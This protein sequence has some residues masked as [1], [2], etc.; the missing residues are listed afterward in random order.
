LA[1]R[2]AQFLGEDAASKPIYERMRLAYE[3]RSVLVHGGKPSSDRKLKKLD[4]MKFAGEIGDD[5]QA[6]IFKALNLLGT[7]EIGES[8]GD[9]FWNNYLFGST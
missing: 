1:L 8:L 7:A 9:E 6:A 4:L 5:I 3:Y 2:A